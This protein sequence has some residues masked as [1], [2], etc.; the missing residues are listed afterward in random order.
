LPLPSFVISEGVRGLR[1]TLKL[2]ILKILQP[3]SLE[4]IFCSHKPAANH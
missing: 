4:S 2:F 1:Q 3:K